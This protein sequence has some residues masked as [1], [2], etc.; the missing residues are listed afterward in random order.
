MQ[1]LAFAYIFKPNPSNPACNE[2]IFMMKNCTTCG[3]QT[4]D[5]SEFPSPHDPSVKIV[6]CFS[7]RRISLPYVCPSTGKA[8]P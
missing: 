5:Y 2:A 6:R 8:G 7:C 1:S 3:A 4:R